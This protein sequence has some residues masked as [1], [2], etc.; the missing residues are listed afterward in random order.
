MKK[1]FISLER[2]EFEVLRGDLYQENK[3]NKMLTIADFVK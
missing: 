3:K 2:L 1:G